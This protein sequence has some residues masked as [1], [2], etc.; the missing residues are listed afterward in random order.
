MRY[1]DSVASMMWDD[2]LKEGFGLGFCP[3]CPKKTKTSPLG[4]QSSGSL[5]SL[6]HLWIGLP[7]PIHRLMAGVVGTGGSFE[8]GGGDMGRSIS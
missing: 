3:L 8:A 2:S 1:L 7:A 6:F 5:R 4:S